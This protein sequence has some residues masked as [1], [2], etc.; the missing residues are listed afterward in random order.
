M[1]PD[2]FVMRNPIL[3]DSDFRPAVRV[4]PQIQ[5]MPL[6]AAYIACWLR[7]AFLQAEFVQRPAI[8]SYH[9]SR[10]TRSS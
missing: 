5:V 1:M 4:F 3:N 10:V 9:P 7:A 6:D 2:D 8:V